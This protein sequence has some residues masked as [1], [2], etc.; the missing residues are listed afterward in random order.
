MTLA[1]RFGIGMFCGALAIAGAASAQQ[2]PLVLPPG[3]NDYRGSGGVFNILPSGQ[4]GVFNLAEEAQMAAVCDADGR[5]AALL[6]RRSRLPAYTIDQLLMYD[7]LLR[8]AP[9]LTPATL[10]DYYKDATF[11]MPPHKIAREYSPGGRAGVVVIRDADFN[12][13]RIYAKNRHDAIFATGYVSAEDRLFFMDVLRHVGR[14][15]MSEFLG[16]SP[17]NLAMDRDAY[18]VA[19]YSEAELQQM[20]DQLDEQDTVLRRAHAA[21]IRGL[22][23]RRQPVHPGHADRSD[24]DARGVRDAPAAMPSNVG[25]HRHRRGGE[26]GHRHLRRRR[27]RRA[28]Q[29][30]LPAGARGALRQTR[31]SRAQVFEDFQQDDDPEKPRTTDDSVPVSGA[32]TG[33]PGGGGV[34][35]SGEAGRGAARARR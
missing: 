4:K 3:T 20:V 1:L 17:A 8:G 26:P 30:P 27:R 13:P 14:G 33:G 25:A 32:G 5:S 19:G 10:T 11:G 16:P 28:E 2:S 35:R 23:R 31:P 22:R 15:R 12:V 7:G 29:L 18:R 21:G 34:S 24:D 6:A 9:T